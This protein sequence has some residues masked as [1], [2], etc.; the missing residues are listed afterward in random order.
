MTV[1]LPPLHIDCD[2]DSGN[3][4]INDASDPRRVR[5]AIRPDTN[6]DHFQ[7]FHFKASGL[8]PGQA[9]TFILRTPGSLPT[10]KPGRV[11]RR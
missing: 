11:I 6:S 9:H 10:T 7:W 4:L 3:I 2:F 5:L 1:T 8:T